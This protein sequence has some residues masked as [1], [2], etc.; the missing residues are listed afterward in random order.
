MGK[1]VWKRVLPREHN[2]RPVRL[3]NCGYVL[4]WEPD[5]PKAF[6]GWYF[7]HRVVMEKVLGRRIESNEDVHHINGERADNRP[8]NLKVMDHI[9]HK[10]LTSREVSA[11]RKADRS[12][13][14]AY[15][16]KY[17]PIEKELL[18]HSA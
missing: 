6:R 18:T 17:G 9:E 12:E 3:N 8:E 5:H 11:R 13:L 7:E 16:Q 4:V 14:A 2:N 10:T 1:R 15:R